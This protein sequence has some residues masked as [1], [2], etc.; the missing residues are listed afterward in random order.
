M[1]QLPLDVAQQAAGAEAKHFCPHP[2]QAKLLFD[3]RQPLN[4]LLRRADPA[5]WLETDRHSG[6]LRVFAD[7]T[8]HYQ[9]DWQ[10]CVGWLLASRS[11]NKFTARHHANHTRAPTLTQP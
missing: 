2:R 9:A 8:S 5:C 6:L 11:L 7:G 10:G 3:Q 4:G 1:L